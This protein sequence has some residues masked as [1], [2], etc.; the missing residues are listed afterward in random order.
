MRGKIS[1]FHKQ[2]NYG[3]IT[4]E[5]GVDVF[6][7]TSEYQGSILEIKDGLA[8]EF[9]RKTNRDGSLRAVQVKQIT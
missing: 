4:G 3:F 5:D 2:R 7:H 8:V 6:F 9:E 1:W